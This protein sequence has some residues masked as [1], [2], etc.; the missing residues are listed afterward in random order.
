MDILRAFGANLIYHKEFLPEENSHLINLCRNHNNDKFIEIFESNNLDPSIED[1]I[2]S[3]SA[4]TNNNVKILLYLLE[5]GANISKDDMYGSAFSCRTKIDMIKFLFDYGIDF[6]TGTEFITYCVRYNGDENIMKFLFEQGMDPNRPSDISGEHL[7]DIAIK[8]YNR[9]TVKIL[10]SYGADPSLST[11]KCL[12]F[13]IQTG[14]EEIIRLLLSKGAQKSSVTPKDLSIMLGSRPS[15]SLI[16]FL[17][18]QD[19]DFSVVNNVK[20]DEPK[21]Y[22][23]KICPMLFELGVDPTQLIRIYDEYDKEINS[24]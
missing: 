11:S 22:I 6:V 5:K 7:I 16:G 4:I 13:A 20:F 2:F 18:D 17:A 3:K 1:N 8:E 9:K 15:Q 12:S 14:E 21:P 23:D 10:I 19:F 24:Q